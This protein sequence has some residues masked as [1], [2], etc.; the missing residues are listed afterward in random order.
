MDLLLLTGAN[1]RQTINLVE[2][3]DT[4]LCLPRFLEQET[5]LPFSLSD[6]LAQSISTFAHVESDLLSVSANAGSESSGKKC[7]TSTG[8]TV[9]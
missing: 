5:K 8:R 9:E 7:L 2:K 6:P 3:D 4:R 1:R